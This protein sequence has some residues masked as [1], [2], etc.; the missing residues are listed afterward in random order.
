MSEAMDVD[1]AVSALEQAR[2]VKGEDA[3]GAVELFRRVLADG[4]I[5]RDFAP[6]RRIRG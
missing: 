1:E 3:E 6:R 5:R 4:G 2:Q